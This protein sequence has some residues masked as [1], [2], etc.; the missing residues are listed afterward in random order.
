MSCKGA[1]LQAGT[2][3][4]GLTKVKKFSKSATMKGEQAGEEMNI[5]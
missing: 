3:W 1:G 2:G 4:M 5:G